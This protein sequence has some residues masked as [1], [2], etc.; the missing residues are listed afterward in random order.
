[1]PQRLLAQFPMQ[2]NRENI[3]KNRVFASKNREFSYAKRDGR[4]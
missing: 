2:I 3:S 4:L 1:V